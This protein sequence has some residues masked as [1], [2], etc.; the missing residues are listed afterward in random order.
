MHL[1]ASCTCAWSFQIWQGSESVL[2]QHHAAVKAKIWKRLALLHQ[3]CKC[4]AS[5]EGSQAGLAML[6]TLQAVHP[7]TP[8]ADLT[9]VLKKLRLLVLQ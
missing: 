3:A 5:I 2:K 7:L 4:T 1:P 9:Q 8:V 6:A